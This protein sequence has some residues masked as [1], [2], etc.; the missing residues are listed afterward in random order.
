MFL[1]LFIPGVKAENVEDDVLIDASKEEFS[2][3]VPFVT[4]EST[5]KFRGTI[6]KEQVK[7]F[8]DELNYDIETYDKFLI[9]LTKGSKVIENVVLYNSNDSITYNAAVNNFGSNVL[10]FNKKVKIVGFFFRKSY[11]C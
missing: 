7:A 3:F 11:K 8:F 10:T 1:F 6:T 2:D 4:D 9:V 5:T